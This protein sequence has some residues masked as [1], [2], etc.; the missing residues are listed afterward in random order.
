MVRINNNG[1]V[2][3]KNFLKT[4]P[5]DFILELKH[6]DSVIKG[7]ILSSPISIERGLDTMLV[8]AAAH[9]SDKTKRS[10]KI[11]YSKGY[12]LSALSAL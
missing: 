7:D 3:S 8:I 12:S 6:I 9:L 10:I 1:K 2:V 11:D 4:R 5:D